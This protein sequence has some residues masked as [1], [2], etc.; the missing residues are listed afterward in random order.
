MLPPLAL[1]VAAP[2]RYYDLLD[3]DALV[4]IV[5]EVAPEFGLLCAAAERDPAAIAVVYSA[6]R[7]EVLRMTQR[8]LPAARP[9]AGCPCG[10]PGGGR[11]WHGDTP[12]HIAWRAA[13]GVLELRARGGAHT[14]VC[15]CGVE[16][17]VGRHVLHEASGAH[18]AWLRTAADGGVSATPDATTQETSCRDI[19]VLVTRSL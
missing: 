8:T 1:V 19:V 12:T 15:V 3:E 2:W 9:S 14:Y 16:V 5:A 13:C 10:G 17:S 18:V 4:G 6:A 7:E 11:P